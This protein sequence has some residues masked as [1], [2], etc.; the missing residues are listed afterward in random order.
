MAWSASPLHLNV[1]VHSLGKLLG[2]GYITSTHSYLLV[3]TTTL[4][5][6]IEEKS[7]FSFVLQSQTNEI[8]NHLALENVWGV[9]Q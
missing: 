1:R 9:P 8:L 5:P 7:T 3:V 2:Q 6:R 4:L